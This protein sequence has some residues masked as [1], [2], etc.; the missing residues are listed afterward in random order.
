[1][2]PRHVDAYV[3]PVL[4][5]VGR[6]LKWLRRGE[7]GFD[8]PSAFFATLLGERLARVPQAARQPVI[9]RLVW[10]GHYL[11]R[12]QR[13]PEASRTFLSGLE[14]AVGPLPRLP[15]APGATSRRPR[16]TWTLEVGRVPARRSLKRPGRWTVGRGRF[17][18]W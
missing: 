2:D 9:E 1:M 15:E 13:A 10:F 3:E 17:R 5:E 16:G 4:E 18:S 6:H 14:A 8:Q 12:E 11:A 7:L